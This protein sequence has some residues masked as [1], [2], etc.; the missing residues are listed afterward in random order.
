MV[1][2]TLEIGI[3]FSST[4]FPETKADFFWATE[5]REQLKERNNS[6]IEANLTRLVLC[7]RN[8]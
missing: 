7:G 1:T 2:D 8:Y 3:S 6:N 5:V 4:T